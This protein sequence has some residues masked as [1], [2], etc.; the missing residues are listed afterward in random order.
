MQVARTTDSQCVGRVRLLVTGEPSQIKFAAMVHVDMGTMCYPLVKIDPFPF[1]QSPLK[2]AIV[3]VEQVLQNK[4][5]RCT[6]TYR[7]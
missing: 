6:T 2:K 1:L 4:T 5:V 3:A 7:S